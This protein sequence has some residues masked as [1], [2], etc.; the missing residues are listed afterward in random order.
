MTSFD[1]RAKDWDADPTKVERAYAI[2]D[3]IIASVPLRS[4][5]RMLEYGCG[6][7]LLGFR[8][9]PHIGDLTR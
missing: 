8:L 9:R 5:M 3:A 7:G 4:D 2:A 6:T 1:D